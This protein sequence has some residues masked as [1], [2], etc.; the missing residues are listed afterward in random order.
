MPVW[1]RLRNGQ[2]NKYLADPLAG[3]WAGAPIA[4]ILQSRVRPWVIGH[5]ETRARTGR[6]VGELTQA[7]ADRWNARLAASRGLQCGHR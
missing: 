4:G 1:P 6:R 5:C 3:Q 2:P 7:R